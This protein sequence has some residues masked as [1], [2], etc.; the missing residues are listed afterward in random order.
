[1]A[2]PILRTEALSFKG[3]ITYPDMALSRGQVHFIVG[4]SGC[5][6]STLLKLFNHVLSPDTGRVFFEDRPLEEWN[7]VLLRRRVSL[8]AQEAWVFPGTL[9]ENFEAVHALR[10][11]PFPEDTEL[12]EICRI[13]RINFPLSQDTLTLS[14]GERHRL[15]M[16]LYLI[17][18]PSVLM[19]DEP[20]AA[21][22]EKNTHEV[23]G[24]IIRYSKEN[25]ITLIVV[26]HDTGLLEPFSEHTIR[27]EKGG[28][29]H[30]GR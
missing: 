4:E 14:G 13:C 29:Q 7:P 11:L 25:G 16:A 23:I 10:E 15:F 18:K 24:N 19:L 3:F 20:T 17:L 26:S 2:S 27:L 9:R 21:L 8:V 28:I 30:G 12:E 1:M 22:D 5:G 6:K